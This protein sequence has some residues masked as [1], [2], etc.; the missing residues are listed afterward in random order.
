ML[1]FCESDR[2]RFLA[3]TPLGPRLTEGALH[4]VRDADSVRRIAAARGVS[5]E[6]VALAWLL[7]LSPQ[8]MVIPG[9]RQPEAIR[10]ST[11]QL[12]ESEFADL[13]RVPSSG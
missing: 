4:R 12:S 13:S 1:R 8:M 9:A 11:F 7:A 6:V 10:D 3:H 5:P 2:V